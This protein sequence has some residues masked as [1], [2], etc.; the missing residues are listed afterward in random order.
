[1]ALHALDGDVLASLDALGLQDLGE[2]TLA[3]LGYQSI[4]YSTRE[5]GHSNGERTVHV[6]RLCMFA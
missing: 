1:M 4:L 5:V 2:G 3:L 6:S